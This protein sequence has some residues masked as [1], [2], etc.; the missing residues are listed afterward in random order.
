MELSLLE[1]LAHDT[2][3]QTSII[4]FMLLSQF[5]MPLLCFPLPNQAYSSLKIRMRCNIFYKT[6]PKFPYPYGLY[7]VSHLHTS[8]TS[9]AYLYYGMQHNLL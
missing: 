9:G 7:Q 3:F 1:I 6:F 4:S 2:K 5:G 8:L